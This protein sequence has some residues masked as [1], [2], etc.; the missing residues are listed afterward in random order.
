MG[1]RLHF[2]HNR[3]KGEKRNRRPL[4]TSFRQQQ[5]R[6][7]QPN[8]SP[9]NII[10]F[11]LI[12]ACIFT[13]IGVGLLVSTLNTQTLMIAYEQCH[14]LAST[15]SLRPIPLE[16]VQSNFH[17]NTT[18]TPKWQLV[19]NDE[20]NINNMTCKIQFQIP[21]DIKSPLYVYYKLTNYYQ[22]YRN[23]IE[24]FDVNQLKGEALA[25]NK[26]NDNC[27]PFK[28]IN[29]K[30]VYPC[31][32]IANTLFND[33]FDRTLRN[34][35]NSSLNIQLTNNNTAW[36]TDKH[37]YKPT[38]YNASQIV[39]PPNWSHIF[40]NGYTD[41][42]IPDLRTWQEFQVWMRASGLPEFYKLA[43][44]NVSKDLQIHEGTYS[45]NIDLHYPVLSYNGTKS[46]VFTT[47]HIVGARN[48]SLSI[49]YFI[50]SG[51][52]IF[53]AI[54]LFI[55]T[56]LTRKEVPI[57]KLSQQKYPVPNV[58]QTDIPLSEFSDHDSL[59]SNNIRMRGI[60]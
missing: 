55:I 47:S 17:K 45:M 33:T 8:L 23:Y 7:W 40:P 56:L 48:I 37:R 10:P 3:S 22:N 4:N 1:F 58:R 6:A 43:L 5:L 15:D 38:K 9:K 35:G 28:E 25:P 30:A 49:V 53:F 16:Y 46:I 36:G 52:S 42:N 59:Y 20:N 27:K 12:I 50:I 39:P 60:L 44:K 32:V 19:Y 31:G 14:L 13:P 54:V 57:H 29:G 24:S 34:I 11:L 2:D 51:L 41:D 26:L 21:N 18:V